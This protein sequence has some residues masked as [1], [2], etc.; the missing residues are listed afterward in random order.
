[1]QNSRELGALLRVKA[2]DLRADTLMQ[3]KYAVDRG[4]H[5]GGAYSALPI[6]T[7][8]YYGGCMRYDVQ[9]PTRE[10]QDVFILSKGHAVAALASVYAD[11][12]YISRESLKNSRGV[13]SLIKG[14][15]GPVIPGVPVSTGPLGHGIAVSCGLAWRGRENQNANVYCLVGDGELQEGSCWEALQFAGAHRLNN[16]C[17]L[18]DKNNGQS[19]DTNQLVL[20]VEP[21][22]EKLAAFGFEVYSVDGGD[23]GAIADAARQLGRYPRPMRPIAV[24]CNTTKGY[25]GFSSVMNKHKANL[26]DAVLDRELSFLNAER[27][28]MVQNVAAF[29]FEESLQTAAEEMGYDYQTDAD[30]KL[31]ALTHREIS[32]KVLPAK[33]RD[34]VLMYNAAQLPVLEPSTRYAPGGILKQVASAFAADPRFYSVDSDLSNASLLY[35]GTASANMRHAINAG[36]AECTMMCLAEGLAVS[37]CNV[38]MST[39]APFFNLQALRRIAV[40]WQEREE[41]IALPDGWLTKGHNLDMTF[42]ATNANLD[43]AVNGATHM[44]N[45]DMHVFGQIAH[46]KVIDVCCPQ[47]LL[48]VCRWIAEGGRGLVYL[49]VMRNPSMPLYGPDYRFTYGKGHVLRQGTRAAIV[50]GGHGVLE[51]LAAAELLA[52][53]GIDAAVIDMPS[54]DGA[55]LAEWVGA[56]RPMLFAE[57]NNGYLYDCFARFALAS[58][59]TIP[60]GLVHTRNTRASDGGLQFVHSGTYEQL[61]EQFGLTAEAIAAAVTGMI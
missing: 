24:I 39:F 36:I 9:N 6:L 46:V 57:Q 52:N 27:A 12:G 51:A 45:D 42:L 14:H 2:C 61:I 60:A 33:P 19:D 53:D 34:K 16:L 30:G 35:D 50:S 31:I 49:R 22:E 26:D 11:V 17:V 38:W 47:Q 13:G 3:C 40:T 20:S 59:V 37:G 4:I 15:P 1:M 28:Q 23:P 44:A 58:G 18:V 56:G 7:A 48:S 10:D 55:L 25:G 32:A 41:T 43:T 8:L 21:L 5:I 54:F 29:P